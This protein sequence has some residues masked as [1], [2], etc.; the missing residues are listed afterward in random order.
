MSNRQLRKIHGEKDELSTL[1]SSLQLEEEELDDAPVIRNVN[2][3]RKKKPAINMFDLLH[4]GDDSDKESVEEPP[5]PDESEED[6]SHIVQTGTKPKKKT[7][8]KKKQSAQLDDDADDLDNEFLVNIAPSNGHETP[9]SKQV[10]AKNVLS[11]EQKNLNS[12]NELKKI[13]GSRV[14]V[15]AQ[16]KKARGRAYV[17]STWLINSKDNWSQIR[18][19]GLSMSLDQTKDGCFY[20]K[21]EHNKEY[22]QIQYD[23]WEAVSSL[24]PTNIVALVNMYPYHIDSLIQLSDICRM[25]EDPQMAGELIERALYILESA[26]HPSFN[27]ASGNCRLEYKQQE[28]RALFLAIFKHLVSI[29]LR[30]C[31]RTALEFCKLLYTLDLD[32]D[33]LAVILMIDFYAIKASEYSWFIEFFGFFESKKNLSQLPNMAFAIALAHFYHSKTDPKSLPLAD[34]YLKQALLMFPGVLIPLLDKCS[35]QA[36]V[37]VVRHEYFSPKT[38]FSHSPSLNNLIQLYIGRSFHLWK[39]AELLPW[40][41]RNANSCLNEV[42]RQPSIA[43]EYEEKRKTRYQGTPRNIY[44][45]ILLSDIKDATATLPQELAAGSVMSFDPLPPV[46]SVSSYSRPTRTNNATAASQLEGGLIS[47]FFRSLLPGFNP[48]EVVNN[49]QAVQRQPGRPPRANVDLQENEEIAAEGAGANLQQS[50]AEL[51]GLDFTPIDTCTK[52][53]EGQELAVAH[54]TE[55]LT[56]QPTLTFV[57]WVVYDKVFDD[58]KQW[59]SLS[60]LRSVACNHN[61]FNAPSCLSNVL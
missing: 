35:I 57:P 25:S 7:K 9:V 30:G 24:N 23:F 12:D 40:L 8:K 56:L 29:G 36:D 5:T 52:T 3:N 31:Y 32:S 47:S 53:S 14:V 43:L 28:N 19:T 38:P 11:L 37:R 42:D 39:D 13:F 51:A 49:Q 34:E 10:A 55:T 46:E 41:E 48:Q 54:G 6:T 18:K 20:F 58:G 16:K 44:R 17:K 15:S 1:A 21:Y 61:G 22:R 4:E 59:S 33:P 60:N 50:C 27:L 2:G 26:F 45:H